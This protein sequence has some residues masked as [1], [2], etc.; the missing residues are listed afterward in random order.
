MDY[1][2]GLPRSGKS[3]EKTKIFQGQGKVRE[4]CKKAEKILVFVKVREF[5][6][7]QKKHKM[8]LLVKSNAMQSCEKCTGTV[9]KWR[10]E[11][12]WSA[13]KTEANL[14]EHLY[15]L[16]PKTFFWLFIC[17]FPVLGIKK[18]SVETILKAVDFINEYSIYFYTVFLCFFSYFLKNSRKQRNK[19]HSN[20]L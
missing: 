13:K 5:L 12:G 10:E 7:K 20:L 11:Y 6:L 14:H 18:S 16:E 1:F 17:Y 8:D 15:L 9:R 19:G 2:T 4:F 3:Q